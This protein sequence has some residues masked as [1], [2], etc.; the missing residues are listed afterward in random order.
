VS[1]EGFW[2]GSVLSAQPTP[3]T[4]AGF[5]KAALNLQGKRH[6]RVVR[7]P[8][9]VD[10]SAGPGSPRDPLRGVPG[11]DPVLRLALRPPAEVLDGAR[12]KQ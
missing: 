1:E 3:L 2:A 6:L 8:G 9:P 12:P 5:V 7:D 11:V 10:P 4:R